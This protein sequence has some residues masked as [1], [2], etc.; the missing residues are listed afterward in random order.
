MAKL[1]SKKRPL[2]MRVSTEETMDY[3]AEM[4]GKHDWHFVIELA[5]NEPEDISELERLLNPSISIP[6]RQFN[7]PAQS[8][9]IER[10]AP[11][12]CGSGKKYKKCCGLNTL[13]A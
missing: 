6:A 3:V 5:E 1:G 4:C 7:L 13:E 9:K 12:P 11:C 2:M 8:E 10:N